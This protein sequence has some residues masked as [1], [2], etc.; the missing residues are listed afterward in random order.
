MPKQKRLVPEGPK[1]TRSV[2]Q[3][4]NANCKAVTN[5]TST[6]G[7]ESTVKVVTE[8]S[9]TF[10]IG[11]IEAFRKFLTRRFD[12][13][14]MKPLRG[15]AG[16]WVKI[17]EPR[18]LTDWGKYHE[19]KPSEAKTPPWWPQDVIYIEPSHLTKEDLTTLAIEMMLVHRKVD[20][21]KRKNQWISRLK[22]AAELAVKM[23]PAADFSSSKNEVYSEEMKKRALE[24]ILPSIFE[25]AQTYE[26]HIVQYKLFEGSGNT[27][28]DRGVRHT[29]KPIPG[30]VIQQKPKRPRR[31]ARSKRAQDTVHKAYGDKTKSNGTMI[32]LASAALPSSFLVD[33]HASAKAS[34]PI[35][36]GSCT[37]RIFHGG[38][39]MHRAAF[40]PS[41]SPSQSTHGLHLGEENQDM[42]RHA[43]T[44]SDRGNMQS[45]FNMPSYTNPLQY[46]TA[47]TSFDGQA[48][49]FADN[50]A[51][52]ALAF[53]QNVPAF[54][55]SFA[56]FNAPTS[57]PSYNGYES[58]I[59]TADGF[60]Y[61]QGI[62]VPMSTSYN[63][64]PM[65]ISMTSSD[66]CMPYDGLPAINMFTSPAVQS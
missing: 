28:P 36:C 25:A 61:G 62:S 35:A 41:S 16:H 8:E 12:E 53:F 66:I 60:C 44:V 26:D 15:I 47:V 34:T 33:A 20:D 17:I 11:D 22:T 54:V 43:R 31:T 42:K 32:R 57:P 2:T 52:Q 55:N 21:V 18:R 24:K 9:H 27:D 63:N 49:Q 6:E 50:N 51:P 59:P 46:S 38:C 40:S 65:S 5:D 58:L 14:T 56:M 23:M 4:L 1:R 64:T 13:L 10:Y 30:P 7:D 37:S 3:D 19:M 45:P 48:Y 39:V 29:W